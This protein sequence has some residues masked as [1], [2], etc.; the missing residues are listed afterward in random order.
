MTLA[1]I[2]SHVHSSNIENLV[3]RFGLQDVQTVT[4][5]LTPRTI[6]TKDQCPT[7]PDEINDIAGSRYRELIGSLQYALL[8]T[9]PDITYALN[10]LAQFLANPGRDADLRVLRYLK[11]MKNRSLHLGG[12][13][14]DIAGFS[15]SDWGGDHDDRKSTGAYIFRLGLGEVSWKSRKQASVAPSRVY[16]Y[17]PGGE[18]GCLA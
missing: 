13:I 16:G 18:G 3:E 17:V 9:C 12:G 7:T 2:R 10:K 14:P 5:P 6:L 15:D 4:T 1:G 8:A 11:G